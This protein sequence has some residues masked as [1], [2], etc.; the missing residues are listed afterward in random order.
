[1]PRAETVFDTVSQIPIDIRTGITDAQATKMVEGLGIKLHKADAVQQIKSLYS[2]FVKTD[3]TMVEVCPER[4]S[5][6]AV[7]AGGR[8]TAKWQ[9]RVLCST[10]C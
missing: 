8:H 10:P 3:C 2:L 1:M 9:H 7:H 4:R 5:M 6:H